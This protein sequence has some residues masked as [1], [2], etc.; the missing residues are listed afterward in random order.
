[1]LALR[2]ARKTPVPLSPSGA[3]CAALHFASRAAMGERLFSKLEDFAFTYGSSYDSYM[4]IEIGYQYFWST[5][6]KGVVAFSRRG[7]TLFVIGGLLAAA[8][9]KDQ[10]LHE[11][12]AFAQRNK[13]TLA[14]FNIG[15]D[16]LPRFGQLGWQINKFGEDAMVTL[17]TI[18]WQGHHY[19]WVRRQESYIQRQGV[20]FGEARRLDMGPD[21]WSALMAELGEVNTASIAKQPQ[22]Q[23]KLTFEG[24]FDPTELQRKRLFIARGSQGFG[25]LEGFLLCNP[26]LNGRE[27]AIEMYRQRPGAPRG[28]VPFM[29][30][31][32]LRMFQAEGLARVSLCLVPAIHTESAMPNDSRLVRLLLVAWSRYG[33]FLFNVRGLY[34]FK[35]R[36][37]PQFQPRY[38]AF[39]RRATW[40]TIV[41]FIAT[42]GII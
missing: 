33:S 11:L 42:S 36:F 39:Y 16:D 37:R 2:K 8:A 35:S 19:S 26:C 20:T 17:P 25:R 13:L 38:V 12:V 21:A 41:D 5:G 27:W 6:E 9:D 31:K 18:S 28:V 22:R 24:W 10:L 14:V 40:R 7:Q 4:V 34:H 29:I 1:M 32:A 15:D 30:V 3:A 23:R